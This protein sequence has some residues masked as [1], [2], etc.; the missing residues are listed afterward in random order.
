MRRLPVVLAAGV[1]G[2]ALLWATG[3]ATPAGS[4][5]RCPKGKVTRVTNGTRAC[6]PAARFR[7]KASAPPSAE[8]SALRQS[9]TDT[10][11]L[12]LKSGKLARPPLP[13]SLVNAIVTTYAAKDAESRAA[14]R[15]ALGT[16]TSKARSHEIASTGASVAVSADG[17]SATATS[18][19]GGT[20][21]GHAITGKIE[22]GA[23][24][25]G[26][27]NVG[28]EL[29]VTDPTGATKTNGLSA[30]DI[31]N[32]NQDCP[33]A[34]GKLPLKG[35]FD[36]TSKEAE[37]FGSKRVHLGEVREAVTQKVTSNAVVTYGKDG[38]AQPFAFTITASHYA[39]RSAQVLAFLQSRVSLT[40]TGTMT[41]TVDPA[42]GKVTTGALATTV[43]VTGA[44]SDPSKPQAEA[45]VMDLLEKL[46]N[47]E[48]A[49]LVESARQAEENC[50]KGYDVSLALITNADFATSSGAGT[51]NATLFVK[52]SATGPLTYQNLTFGSKVAE[53]TLINPLSVDGTWTV[54]IEK[55]PADR[56]K[57][58]WAPGATGLTTTATIH[59]VFPRLMGGPLITDTPGQPGPSLLAPTPTTFELPLSGGQQSI[60]GGVF[61][62]DGRYSHSGTITVTPATK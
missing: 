43:K 49:R 48:L 10:L 12:R 36:V 27:L 45:K 29:T 1:L 22:F 40:G 8:A 21:G 62:A 3:G 28:F 60:G 6:V 16:K 23:N 38:K 34:D 24:A 46:M 18:S 25:A 53:C 2:T 26:R 59:C 17:S 57:V 35:G 51:L 32:R 31:L 37:T 33:G 19:F 5:K 9:L 56:L 54:T 20:A 44:D 47:D 4:A 58:T 61:D 13:A 42:T 50:G 7:V 39:G 14:L 41:G 15:A 30:R 11:P 55:T 52:T